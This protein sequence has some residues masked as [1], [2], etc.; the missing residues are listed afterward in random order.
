MPYQLHR[1]CRYAP[2]SK[3]TTTMQVSLIIKVRF[4]RWLMHKACVYG[5]CAYLSSRSCL[6]FRLWHALDTVSALPAANLVIR[7]R[8]DDY[9]PSFKEDERAFCVF[10]CMQ[11]KFEARG[12]HSRSYLNRRCYHR[13]RRRAS[14]QQKFQRK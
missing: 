9:H 3:Q 14:R 2:V 11:L 7:Q 8:T 6:S 5:A 13:Y 12:S 10:S 1:G 4:M